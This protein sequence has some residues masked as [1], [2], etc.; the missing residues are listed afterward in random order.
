MRADS[1][2]DCNRFL[3]YETQNKGLQKSSLPSSEPISGAECRRNSAFEKQESRSVA[4]NSE[5]SDALSRHVNEAISSFAT[6]E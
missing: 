6:T 5:T 4:N 3:A 1:A 2:N